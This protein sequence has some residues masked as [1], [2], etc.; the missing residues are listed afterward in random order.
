MSFFESQVLSSSIFLFVSFSFTRPENR[1]AAVF[2]LSMTL[3]VICYP[4]A[5]GEFPANISMAW[6]RKCGTRVLQFVHLSPGPSS[7]SFPLLPVQSSVSS[8]SLILFPRIRAPS[9]RFAVASY[10]LQRY[11]ELVS[12]T[13]SSRHHQS[14]IPHQ[15]E[16]RCT[17][18]TF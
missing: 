4:V 12:Q 11:N 3:N 1:I 18:S 2:R 6:Q 8:Q 15:L 10:F 14:L 7:V 13:L 17:L 16:L 5:P 9:W